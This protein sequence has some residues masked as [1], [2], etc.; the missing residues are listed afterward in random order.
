MKSQAGGAR[1]ARRLF[2]GCSRAASVAGMETGLPG[3]GG[4]GSGD[5]TT[6]MTFTEIRQDPAVRWASRWSG[7]VVAEV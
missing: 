3:P 6:M 1:K 5:G 7:F 4:E 2:G